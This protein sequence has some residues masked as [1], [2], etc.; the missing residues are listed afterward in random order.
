[1]SYLINPWI[2]FFDFTG[3]S[4]RKEFFLYLIA[5]VTIGFAVW[6]TVLIGFLLLP[7]GANVNGTSYLNAAQWFFFIL[8]LPMIALT[9]RRM[10]D[11]FSSPYNV[12]WSLFPFVG[13]VVICAIACKP[14][15]VDSWVVLPDGREMRKSHA[16]EISRLDNTIKVAGGVI[17]GALVMASAGSSS[18]TSTV[19]RSSNGTKNRV[20]ASSR[21]TTDK[22]FN[23][24]TTILGGRSG[25]TNN[26]GSRVKGYRN[27]YT[28]SLKKR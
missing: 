11:S 8:Q 12:F 3:T 28:W 18:N 24:H 10:H 6:V 15:F 22:G 17:L 27:N 26:K 1:M 23:Q 9:V 5:S 21:V 4:N 19:S 2:K 13:P 25:Y 7:F 14:T 16:L 20:P